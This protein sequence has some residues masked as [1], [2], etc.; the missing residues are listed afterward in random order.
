[1]KIALTLI[2]LNLVFSSCSML[3]KKPEPFTN[4]SDVDTDGNIIDLEGILNRAEEKATPEGKTILNTGRAMV[5]DKK[6]VRGSCWDY[7]NA[8]YNNS[9]LPANERI[10]PLKSKIRGPY[11]D[12][13]SIE[14]GDWLYFINYSFREMDHS[15]IFIEWTDFEKKRAVLLSYVGGKKKKPGTYKIY[16]LRHVYYIIRHK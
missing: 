6:I 8:V 15:G 16:D 1:M 13:T 11:A 7:A 2:M 4:I 3:R 10:T 5:N 14:A 9:G 12:L